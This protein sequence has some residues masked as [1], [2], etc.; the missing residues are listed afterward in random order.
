MSTSFGP[1][2]LVAKSA[3]DFDDSVPPPLP[4]T[5]TVTPHTDLVQGQSVT[6]TGANFAPSSF[7]ALTE[8]L[9]DSNYQPF[10]SGGGSGVQTDSTGG[11]TQQ[12]AVR[13]GVL[14]FGSSYPPEVEDCAESP[15]YCSIIAFS[16]DGQDRG[17][18]AIDFDP[19]VPIPV[20]D[21][22]VSPQFDIPDRGLVHVHSS[23]FT[24][25][26]RVLVSQC[27]AGAPSYGYSCSGTFGPLNVLQADGNGVVDTSIRVHRVITPSDGGVVIVADAPT[28]C[29]DAVGTCVM[30]VQ[31]IDDPL[32]LSDVPLGVDPTT[33][34]AP[35]TLTMTPAG[36]FDDG[37]QV[38]VHGAG[39]TP[40]AVLGLAQCSNAAKP[41]SESC[42]SGDGGIF[43]PFSADADGTF[44]RTVTMHTKVETVQGTIDCSAAGS[45]VLLAANRADYVVE[46]ASTPIE[47]DGAAEVAGGEV[48]VEGISQTRA[49]AFTGAGGGTA[50]TA[51]AGFAL[52]LVGGAL[53]LLSRRGRRPSSTAYATV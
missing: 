18:Q 15:G 8:C 6:V 10:C 2:T 33:V 25:G 3:L 31:S 9:T 1:T 39:F 19:S 44:T 28:N 50:P 17:A 13:R 37:Q 20:P 53:V 48:R 26:E 52:L 30:R 49:L 14:D 43:T 46:R 51:L 29:S 40:N 5:I 27:V 36:P 24:A 11:F 12:F 32:V 4:P 21:T 42:D 35:P 23:G 41:G 7:V 45:C 22:T 16:F 34:A 38:V 47:F